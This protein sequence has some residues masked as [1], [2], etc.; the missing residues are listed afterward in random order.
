MTAPGIPN[1]YALSTSCFGTRLGHV[2]DQVFA[3]V[4][5]GFRRIELGLSDAP[6]AMDGTD[7]AQ[8]ETGVEIVSMVAGCRDSADRELPVTR[9]ASLDETVAERAVNSVRR[10]AR[11]A[12]MWG[13]PT[14]VLRGSSIEDRALR[15]EA[16]SFEAR[17][18]KDG[19]GPELRE[20]VGLYV[21]RVQRAGQPQLVNLCRALH[22]LMTE[23][24]DLAFAVEP[25][26]YIDDL[27]GFDAM[28]WVLDDLAR[29]RVSYWHDV[30]RVHM[31]EKQGLPKQ[32][33]WLETYGRRMRGIHLQDAA[34]DETAMPIGLGEVD[35]QMVVEFT[36]KDALKVLELSSR[37]GRPEILSSVQFLLGM[38]F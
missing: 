12:K 7:E 3:A 17:A 2:Q 22:E 28:G 14:V 35:F 5:M 19:V 30:G 32:E 8:R 4:G 11:L 20:E 10:H 34:D 16:R 24:P 36:P 9:L 23:F 15:A 31:R 38:G 27:L 26:R 33:R 13:C 6:A 25:G 18:L 1:P 29:L 21:Q 37:H